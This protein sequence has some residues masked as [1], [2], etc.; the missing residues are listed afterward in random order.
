MV[1]AMSER[2]RHN[3]IS[4]FPLSQD[5]YELPER[6]IR[7]NGN[8]SHMFKPNNFRVVQKFYQDKSSM[9]ITFNEFNFQTS[10]C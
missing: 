10:S 8:I 2:S 3:I 6:N 9:D 1:Q 7:A 4:I 5:Y